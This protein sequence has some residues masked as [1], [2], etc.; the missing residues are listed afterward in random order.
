MTKERHHVEE[1]GKDLHQ[2]DRLQEAA[3]SPKTEAGEGVGRHGRE[4]HAD[5]RGQD[6]Q[7]ERIHHP[8]RKGKRSLVKSAR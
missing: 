6:G 3:P 4:D 5:D 2:Q 7:L 8:E 1:V